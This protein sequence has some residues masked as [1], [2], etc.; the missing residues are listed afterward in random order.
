VT[1]G[2]V[3][4]QRQLQ[5]AI[6]AAAATGRT[7]VFRPMRY[8]LDDPAGLQLRSGLTLWMYGAVFQLSEE[9]DRDG[10]AFLGR[11]VVGVN[12]LGGEVA[13]LRQKWPDSVNIAGVRFV[14][15]S[16]RIRVRDMYL[17]DLSSNGVGVF[18]GGPDEWPPVR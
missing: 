5:E 16:A 13:G 18:G 7:L 14:G 3:S 4:Y 1:D 17:H 2:S 15:R 11:D 8:L 9:M 6:D 10:Q 12:L